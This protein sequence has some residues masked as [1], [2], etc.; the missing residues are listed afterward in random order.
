MFHGSLVRELVQNQEIGKGLGMV[1]TVHP[2]QWRLSEGRALS[3][4][5]RE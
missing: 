3:D 2:R 5:K 1:C 4:L